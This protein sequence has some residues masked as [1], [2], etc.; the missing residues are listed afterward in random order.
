MY[1]PKWVWASGRSLGTP[2]RRG[3]APYRPTL[4]N[5]EDRRVMTRI[6]D[7]GALG[8][9]GSYAQAINQFG[10]VTGSSVP[11]GG[12]LQH[13]FLYSDGSMRDLGVLG[14]TSFGEAINNNGLVAGYSNVV[15][16]SVNHAVLGGSEDLGTLPGGSDSEAYGIND[17][18]FV[19]GSSN[20]SAS[21][22]PDA[23][24]WAGGAVDLGSVV[25]TPSQARAINNNNQITGW[26]GNHAFLY[27]PSEG[28]INLV[29]AGIG[30]AINASGEVAGSVNHSVGLASPYDTTAFVYQNGQTIDLGGLPG[31]AYSSANGINDLGQVVGTAW[32]TLPDFPLP[33]SMPTER[34]FLYTDG[35]MI[36]LN[37]LLPA[38]SGW[39][40]FEANG[41]NDQGQIAGT[42]VNPQG[43]THAFILQ[44]DTTNLIKNGGFETGDFT[45]WT[46]YGNLGYTGVDSTDVHTGSFAATLGPI[47]SL[48]YLSQTVP[49]TP[50]QTYTLSYW[51]AHPYPD[52]LAPDP[53]VPNEFQV[54]IGGTTVSDQ[55]NLGNFDYTQFTA[56]Y[57][58]TGFTTTIRFDFQEDP[59]FF[60]LD[61]VDFEP[62]GTAPPSPSQPPPPAGGAHPFETGIQPMAAKGPIAAPTLNS[63]T[64]ESLCSG[65]CTV[66]C[67]TLEPAGAQSSEGNGSANPTPPLPMVLDQVFQFHESWEPVH[68][69][70]GARQFEVLKSALGEDIL[71]APSGMNG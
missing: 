23:V 7:L 44:L 17:N 62:G 8:Q 1:L 55:V 6:L 21:Y 66:P 40:L 26:A 52:W 24:V 2:R 42:G 3:T 47:G 41:I 31:Y 19:V 25:G 36:D 58:A 53:D 35:Q 60:Y 59:A 15:G 65:T 37:S 20:S 11:S 68:L 14:N 45:F 56:T 13:A 27:D 38:G 69:R 29:D 9:F 67:T 16:G 54:S 12:T 5:L 22:A 48:G 49:T 43:Q 39:T 51:L 71:S 32:R 57:T 64:L 33:P 50:G 4:E 63:G 30:K 46:Q 28:V 34:P 18:N 70:P 61:D 10:Q